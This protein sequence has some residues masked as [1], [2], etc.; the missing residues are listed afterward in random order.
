L[1]NPR[2]STPVTRYTDPEFL[3][4]RKDRGFG[5]PANQRVFDLQINYRVH[6]V[7]APDCVNANFR[8]TDVADPAGFGE[9]GDRTNCILDRNG[10]IE[11]RRTIDVDVVGSGGSVCTQGS[12]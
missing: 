9:T 6:S 5:T 8:Q 2:E 4:R 10:R 11:A 12:S 7:C 3:Q 1:S